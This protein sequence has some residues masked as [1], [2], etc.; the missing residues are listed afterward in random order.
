VSLTIDTKS[1]ADHHAL[2]DEYSRTIGPSRALDAEALKL[3][4]LP[5]AERGMRS[6]E[7][8]A[9]IELM[10]QTAPP[11]MPIPLAP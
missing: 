5:I 4:R 7:C 9:E 11:R 6:A 1:A 2:R 3:E 8:P 10:W